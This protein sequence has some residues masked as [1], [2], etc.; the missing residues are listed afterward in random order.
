MEP[1]ILQS[2]RLWLDQPTS[3]DRDRI[4]E[5]CRDPVFE[6]FMTLPWPYEPKHADFFVDE[7]VPRGWQTE[8]EFTWA[9]RES[10]G[11][12]LLGAIGARTVGSDFGYWLG[13][14]HRGRGLMSEAV[15][16]VLH[17][18]YDQ[19]WPLVNWECVVG[20]RASAGIARRNGFRYT[21][22][23]PTDLVFRDGSRP[24]AWHGVRSATDDGTE[25]PGW[26]A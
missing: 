21:G 2:E 4:V 26:P 23:A 19:G 7:L 15:A 12:P 13:A 1:V 18:L 5:Y 9:L 6:A 20:N 14:P 22:E 16:S 17:W 24:P 8:T 10:E 11:G 3:A 25:K